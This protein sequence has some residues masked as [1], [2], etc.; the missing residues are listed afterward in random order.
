M[1][2]VLVKY[3]WNW[4]Q[5]AAWVHDMFCD[6]NLVKNHK[7]VNNANTISAIEKMHI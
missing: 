4:H 5:V 2:K 3:W 1:K 6:F 7:I